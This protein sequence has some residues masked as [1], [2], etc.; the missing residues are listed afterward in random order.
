MVLCMKIVVFDDD[1]LDRE[2]L[3]SIIRRWA[4]KRGC[5]EL[6]CLEFDRV[7][8]LE[9]SLPDVLFSDI[10]FLDIMTPEKT[11]AGFLLAEKIH[12]QN[13]SANIVFTTNSS[14]YWSNAFEIFALHYL[15]K[16]VQEE[17]IFKVLD[18]VYLSPS[19]RAAI[20][21][22][23]PGSGQESIIKFDQ[24]LYIEAKTDLHLGYAYLTDGTRLEINLSSISFSK[25]LEEKLSSDFAQCHRSMIVNLNYIVKYDLHTVELKNCEREF[26]IGKN[27][28]TDFL[29]RLINHQ[30]G[31]R[32]L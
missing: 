28:R 6:I 19:K 2:M 13:P 3:L 23:L 31:L 16:P 30:K 18:L 27:Y 7:S 26:S 25:L 4:Q 29:N 1:A 21:A 12:T 11:N 22:I 8:R 10:F 24:I 15:M 20:S 32:V 9:F 17:K 5:S 14:E